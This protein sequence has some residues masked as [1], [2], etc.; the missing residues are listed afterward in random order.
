MYDI[1]ARK[2]P[3]EYV[4]TCETF[5]NIIF[6]AVTTISLLFARNNVTSS[7]RINSSNHFHRI[8]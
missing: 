3:T 8:F 2:R 1:P 5:K 7:C 4:E 6:S